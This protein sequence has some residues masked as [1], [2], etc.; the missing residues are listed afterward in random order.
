QADSA[1]GMAVLAAYG[2]RSAAESGAGS[3]EGPGADSRGGSSR[4]GASAFSALRPMV[5]VRTTLEP[6]PEVSR[7]FDEPLVALGGGR[8]RRGEE[9]GRGGGPPGG[10]AG[11]AGGQGGR[12]PPRR[13]SSP[14][15]ARPCGTRRT[16]TPG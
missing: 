5:R 1:L 9:G 16:A 12:R 3:G 2:V 8:G 7:R 11:S 15:T 14:A 13:C 4:K 6:R 10:R